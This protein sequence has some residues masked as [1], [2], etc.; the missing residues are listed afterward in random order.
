MFRIGQKVVCI[1]TASALQQAEWAPAIFPVVGQIYHIRGI[2]DDSPELV[3]LVEID[4]SEI[5]CG[6]FGYPAD[7]A[8]PARAFRPIVERKTDISIFMRMLKPSKVP[9]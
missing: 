9:A 2:P 8:F 1:Y 6:H 3:W 4:N 7:G 5:I